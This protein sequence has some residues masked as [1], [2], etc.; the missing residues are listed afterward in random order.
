MQT[1]RLPGA[2]RDLLASDLTFQQLKVLTVLVTL[3]D[4][5]TVRGLAETFGV[6]MASM[7][8]MLD[9]LVAQDTARRDV[10]ATDSRVRRIHATPQGREVVR[11]LVGARPEFSEDIL[12][13]LSLEDLRAL[14]QGLR[15][16]EAVFSHRIDGGP[17]A[18]VA[19]A[20]AET[21]ELS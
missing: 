11:K 8:N 5:V 3:P 19:N 14:T 12:A 6:S 2:V 13:N 16:V 4:G 15:A 18:L 20:S 9:R 17:A 7:S 10:D 1:S 21:R